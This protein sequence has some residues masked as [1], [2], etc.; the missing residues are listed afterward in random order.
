MKQFFEYY[1]ANDD[2]KLHGIIENVLYTTGFFDGFE[3][4]IIIWLYCLK[5]YE[6]SDLFLESL[7]IS[8]QNSKQ[9]L[10]Q[11]TELNRQ[12]LSEDDGDDDQTG[13]DIID[14]IG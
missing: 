14:Q 12:F 1:A 10:E 4:E 13:L 8:A 5:N 11:L 3:N 7:V 9:F 6:L 2:I